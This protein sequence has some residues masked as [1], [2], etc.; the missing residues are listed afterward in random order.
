ML[1][2]TVLIS[3]SVLIFFLS[4]CEINPQPPT[5]P[6]IDQTLPQVTDI[7]FLNEV[8]EVGFEWVPSFDDRVEGYYIYRSTPNSQNDKLQRIATIKDK[9]TSHFVDVK[10]MPQTKYYYRF[11]TF[12]RDKRESVPSDTIA[13]ETLPLIESVSFIKAITGLPSRV[14]LIWRPHTSQRVESYLIERNEFNSTEWKQIAKVDGRLNAEYIDAGLKENRV[15]RYRVKVKTYDGLI[16]KSSQI[17]EAG[18]KPLPKEVHGLT[19]SYDIP[20]KIALNWNAAIEND[21]SYYKI[22]RALNPFIFYT[23]LAKT[24]DTF[25]EDLINENGSSYYYLVTSVD[26]DGLESLK[27]KVSIKGSTLAIP[28]AVYISSSNYDGKSIRI[29]WKNQDDRAIRYNVIKEFSGQKQVITGITSTQFI[30]ENVVAGVEYKYNVVAIDKFGLS[31]KNS[32]NTIIEIPK[33]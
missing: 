33:E 19:A 18:T 25:Y 6:V 8:S 17:V 32:E 31:S 23:Y 14:K 22:Y 11:S 16:S 24:Q 15:F 4:G 1:R 28:E 3:L 30:D 20:K 26:K 29:E 21:F 9:Y 7:K 13:T 10:L 2:S 12:S 27:Q 5:K